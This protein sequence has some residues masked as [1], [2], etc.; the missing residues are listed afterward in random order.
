MLEKASVT[1]CNDFIMTTTYVISAGNIYSGED[2]A[3]M[4]VGRVMWPILILN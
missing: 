4:A 1:G 2:T 3:K